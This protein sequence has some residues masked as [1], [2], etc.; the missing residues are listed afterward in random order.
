MTATR[1]Y[2]V[3]VGDRFRPVGPLSNSDRLL[4]VETFITPTKTTDQWLAILGIDGSELKATI[5]VKDL[6]GDGYAKESS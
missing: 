4:T 2:G 5:E 1:V 6:N 3:S